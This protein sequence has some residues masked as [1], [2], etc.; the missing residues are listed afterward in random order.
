MTEGP[1]PETDAPEPRPDAAFPPPPQGPVLRYTP[2]QPPAAEAGRLSGGTQQAWSTPAAVPQPPA[3]VPQPPAGVPQ[4]PAAGVPQ[5]GF[6]PAQQPGGPQQWA[7]Q[8]GQPKPAAEG[9][10]TPAVLA[11]V[12]GVLGLVVPFL[13]LPLDD[14]RAWIAFPFAVVGLALGIAGCMGRRPMKALAVIGIV[15]AALALLAGV[16]MVGNRVADAHAAPVAQVLTR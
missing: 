7:G 6:A 2:G 10:A 4:P 11:L 9:N 8:P 5:P 1:Q 15:F 14:V 3:G 13:P 16:I 12:L